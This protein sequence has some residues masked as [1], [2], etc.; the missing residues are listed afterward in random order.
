MVTVS[1]KHASAGTRFSFVLFL[2]FVFCNLCA[3]HII[4]ISPTP[5]LP[6][7]I[8]VAAQT[9]GIYTVTNNSAK[10]PVHIIDQSQ[11]PA[12]ITVSNNSCANQLNPGRS[13]TISLSVVAP[14]ILPFLMPL[15]VET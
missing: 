1:N 3:A 6:T 7:S 5:G 15:K 2:Y 9:T 12:T 10:T 14:V 8:H 13:C 4:S 11:L